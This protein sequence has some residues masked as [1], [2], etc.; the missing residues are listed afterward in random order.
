MVGLIAVVWF[1][2]ELILQ[3]EG[4]V[5]IVSIKGIMLGALYNSQELEDNEKEHIVQILFFV[6]SFNFIWTTNN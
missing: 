5:T 6:F 1:L 2:I 3:N 4:E